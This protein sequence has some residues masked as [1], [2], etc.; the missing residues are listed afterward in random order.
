MVNHLFSATK[1]RNVVGEEDCNYVNILSEPYKVDDL[2]V[3]KD[4][5]TIIEN[6]RNE[7]DCLSNEIDSENYKDLTIFIDPIGH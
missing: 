6:V 5:Y 1:F 4:F 3:P 7:I 2:M